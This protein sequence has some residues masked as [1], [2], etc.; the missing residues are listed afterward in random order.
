VIKA[1]MPP[2]PAELVNTTHFSVPI[3]FTLGG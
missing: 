3:S 2:K 1:L